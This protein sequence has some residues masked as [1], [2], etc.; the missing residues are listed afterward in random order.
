MHTHKVASALCICGAYVH[1]KCLGFKSV[2]N[3]EEHHD[4][5]ACKCTKTKPTLQRDV[6]RTQNAQQARRRVLVKQRR[7]QAQSERT[8]KAANVAQNKGQLQ[9]SVRTESN[10]TST[11]ILGD[12]QPKVEVGTYVQ[13]HGLNNQV[14]NGREG[15]VV[16]CGG[17][18]AEVEVAGLWKLVK[19]RCGNLKVMP[20]HR[21]FRF[22]RRVPEVMTVTCYRDPVA[23][24]PPQLTGSYYEVLGVSGAADA[25]TIK[26]AYTKLSVQVHPDKNP[27]HAEKATVLFKQV[28]EAYNCLKDERS[29][30]KYDIERAPNVFRQCRG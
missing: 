19:V 15:M 28:N 26:S 17:D 10:E 4:S 22:K 30:R 9:T 20:M 1:L 11:A 7:Q 18:K 13:L 6:E 29:R 8:T 24:W 14:Y 12:G 23:T 21:S 27:R 25:A 3:F 16:W 5:F 2:R